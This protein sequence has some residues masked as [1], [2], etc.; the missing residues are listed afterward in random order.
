VS[1]RLVDVTARRAKVELGDG[2]FATC[3]LSEDAESPTASPKVDLASLTAMLS[4]R[5]KGG[6]GAPSIRTGQVRSFRIAQL[7]PG[8]KTIEL[9]LAD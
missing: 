3:R 5:W 7:D 4:S 1:G 6:G 2:V 8:A 9:E